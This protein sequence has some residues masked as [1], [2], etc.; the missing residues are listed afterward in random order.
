MRMLQTQQEQFKQENKSFR[1]LYGFGILFVVLSHC[2]GGGFEML[3]NWMHFGAFHLAIFVFGSGYFLAD[4]P[5]QKTGQFIIRK[6]KKLLVPLWLWNAF[7]GLL[8]MILQKIGFTYDATVNIKSLLLS[9]INSF[10]LFILDMGAWFVFPF[11]M[12]QLLY[13]L[14][15][16]FLGLLH[17]KRTTDPIWQVLFFIVGILTVYAS[18]QGFFGEI[19][20]PL[21]RIAYFMPFYILGMWYHN[22]ME[23]YMD[24][25][26][27]AALLSGCLIAA[28]L[29][30]AH[31][32]RVVYAIPSS[33]DYPFGVVATYFSACIGILFWLTVSKAL[34]RMT[35]DVK[36]LRFI[37][38]HTWDIMFHQFMGILLVKVLFFL[39]NRCFGIFADFD[40]NAFFSDIW[41]L[42]LPK[43]MAEFKALYVVGAIAFSVLVG[44]AVTVCKNKIES[45][46]NLQRWE[47]N[48]GSA[49]N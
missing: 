39:G 9:P 15:A 8:L 17:K 11:F 42:Y 16:S 7:Y 10:Q 3:S 40:K 21:C 14:G 31:F 45:Y 46:V 26:P 28:L 44:K 27:V 1:Y 49:V 24:R 23:K 38:N 12:V 47:I 22:N 29:L 35:E 18:G 4:R 5:V 6:I 25:L 41:Y 2:D 19:P 33:C 34:T 37:G 48:H 43:Q 20:Q 32:G 36:I 30:N 13:I